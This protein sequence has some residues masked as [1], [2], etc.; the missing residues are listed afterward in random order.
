M[1]RIHW[2]TDFVDGSHL[3]LD[4]NPQYVMGRPRVDQIVVQFIPS[5]QT[6]V[7]NVVADAV[8]MV[9]GR[10]VSLQQGAEL[11]DQWKHGTVYSV[12]GDPRS[13]V[14]QHQNP[15]PAIIGNPQ[16]QDS[17]GTYSYSADR[18]RVGE[19]R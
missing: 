14:P 10:S 5:P 9:L 3:T 19:I 17:D 4:A 11:R 1:P 6:L 2:L 8:D 15:T 18:P 16:I 12:S 7:A 13:L